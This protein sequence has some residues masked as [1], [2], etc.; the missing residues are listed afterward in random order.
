MMANH[1]KSLAALCSCLRGELPKNVDWVSLIGLA[2][3]TLT[4]PALMN[5]VDRFQ[6][7]IPPHVRNYVRE[8]YVR[9]QQR[10]QRLSNQLGE[11]LR[12]LNGIGVTP[13]LLKGAAKLATA[14]SAVDVARLISD[15]DIMIASEEI[16]IALEALSA[17]GYRVY[18]Q[19]PNSAAKWYMDLERDGDVGMIDLH[20]QLP[21]HDYFYRSLGNIR[22]HCSVT[23]SRVGTAYVPLPSYQ[24][25]IL[26]VH[27]QFQDS[28]YW[29]GNIDLRHLIDLRELASSAEGIDWKLLSAMSESRL[30]RNALETQL[31]ALHSLFDVEVPRGLLTR[32]TPRLQFRRRLIQS[33]IPLLR[34]ALLATALLDY[35]NYRAEVGAEE[36]MTKTSKPQQWSLPKIHNLRHLFDLSAE[37]RPGKV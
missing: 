24:A 5:F 34:P 30:Y 20:H 12:A 1:N 32:L 36:R 29:T 15:L 37:K 22:Q 2:N 17:L 18:F 6:N 19:A 23:T 26:I 33:R 35:K 8:I 31:V 21:G 16:E 4:T 3:D 11:A 27:D 25:L 7:E 10:N 9:N 13:V 28:D 14:E